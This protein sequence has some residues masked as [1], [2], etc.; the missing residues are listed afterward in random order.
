MLFVKISSNRDSKMNMENMCIVLT[1]LCK[2]DKIK[3]YAAL[4]RIKI[5]FEK[6]FLFQLEKQNLTVYVLHIYE[7]DTMFYKNT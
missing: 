5:V 1:V 2:I 4:Y 7:Y 6:D 3:M